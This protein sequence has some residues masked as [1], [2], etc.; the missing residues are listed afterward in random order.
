[1]NWKWT[2]ENQGYELEAGGHYLPDFEIRLPNAEMHFVEV[3]PDDF[4]KFE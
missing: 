1:M 4:D 2:Y 3:K